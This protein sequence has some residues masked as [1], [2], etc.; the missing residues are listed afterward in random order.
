MFAKMVEPL[1]WEILDNFVFPGN[2]TTEALEAGE[3]FG[4]KFARAVKNTARKGEHDG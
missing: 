4:V 1:Q 3:A 2:P